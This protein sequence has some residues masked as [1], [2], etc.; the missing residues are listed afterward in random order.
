MIIGIDP[1]AQGGICLLGLDDGIDLYR[2]PLFEEVI[3]GKKVKHISVNKLE[4]ILSPHVRWCQ[5]IY[6]E[7]VHSIYGTSAAS[8]FKMGYNLGMLHSLLDRL[9]GEYF[10]IRPKQWQKVWVESDKVYRPNKRIDTKA[11]SLNAA[12][13]LFPK[14]TFIPDGCRSPHDGVVDAT[15]IA[16]NGKHYG[17]Q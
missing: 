9:F 11:T 15:L 7:D 1:G 3:N 14:E 2:M 10:L 17:V 12:K 16:Y 8:N 13:R 4:K 5:G 6:V